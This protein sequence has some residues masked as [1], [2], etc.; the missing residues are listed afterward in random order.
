MY[1][2]FVIVYLKQKYP[3]EQIRPWPFHCRQNQTFRPTILD[4]EADFNKQARY[5]IPIILMIAMCVFFLL[6]TFFPQVYQ[7]ATAPVM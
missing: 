4:L 5:I 1:D 6:L 3:V 7:S 2:I